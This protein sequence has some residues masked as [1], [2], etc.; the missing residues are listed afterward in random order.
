MQ[1][2]PRS[3]GGRKQAGD[4]DYLKDNQF[5]DMGLNLRMIGR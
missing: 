3:A 1:L 5:H 4:Y 2:R